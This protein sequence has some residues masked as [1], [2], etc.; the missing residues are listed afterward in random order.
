MQVSG[1]IRVQHEYEVGTVT[2]EQLELVEGVTHEETN[3]T[4][5]G[6]WDPLRGSTEESPIENDAKTQG[7]K[8]DSMTQPTEPEVLE[9]GEGETSPQSPTTTKAPHLHLDLRS[10]MPPPPQSW[11]PDEPLPSI[12]QTKLEY[13]ESTSAVQPKFPQYVEILHL[14]QFPRRNGT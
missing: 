2:Q 8:D 11:D 3:V 1:S 12:V 9:K 13:S 7:T 4:A 14:F 5:N 6:N 10:A